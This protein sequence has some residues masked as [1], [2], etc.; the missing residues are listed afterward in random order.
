M[1]WSVLV[2]VLMLAPLGT[3]SGMPAPEP[4]RLANTYSIIAKDPQTGEFGVAVQSHYFSVGPIVPWAE[5]GVG[6]VATQSLVLVIPSYYETHR[7]ER[8]LYAGYQR[9]HPFQALLAKPQHK[10]L[11]GDFAGELSG[12][13]RLS[14]RVK[15]TLTPAN[16]G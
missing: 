15:G 6:A 13:L 4:T 16:P 2:P 3:G 7:S 10:I 1:D 14:G 11:V 8:P 9:L 12:Y 5:S